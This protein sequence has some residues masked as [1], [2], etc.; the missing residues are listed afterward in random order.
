MG[1]AGRTRS[2]FHRKSHL[3]REIT[4][5][6]PLSA[7]TI[8]ASV[9]V[10]VNRLASFDHYA[11]GRRILSF[12]PLF[13]GDEDGIPEDYPA[14]RVELGLVGDKSEGRLAAA[15]L[16][17]ERITEVRPNATSTWTTACSGSGRLS[18]GRRARGSSS[19]R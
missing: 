18:S 4:K 14:D 2:T 17:A 5:L 12:D 7:G 9:F 3:D 19:C 15:L 13:P 16:L 1:R 6:R 10:N 8:T 11:D